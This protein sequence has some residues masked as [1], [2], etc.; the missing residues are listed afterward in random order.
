MLLKASI[1][2]RREGHVWSGI[3][4]LESELRDHIRWEDNAASLLMTWY[5]WGCLRKEL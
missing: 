2:A 4:A 1:E 5:E 3:T